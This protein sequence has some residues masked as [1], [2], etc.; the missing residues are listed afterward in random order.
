MGL[1]EGFFVP[2]FAFHLTPKTFEE[3]VNNVVLAFELMQD[4]GLAK[5]K[6]R[7]EG[8]WRIIH[9]LKMD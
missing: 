9:G 8:T 3:K 1:L 4:V 6:A 2:L 5:P 7:P